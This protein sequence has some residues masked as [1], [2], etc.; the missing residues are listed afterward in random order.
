MI[1]RGVTPSRITIRRSRILGTL[2]L[3]VVIIC[4]AV[5]LAVYTNFGR[6][7][8]RLGLTHRTIVAFTLIANHIARIDPA[9]GVVLAETPDLLGEQFPTMAVSHDGQALFVPQTI[10]RDGVSQDE[11]LVLSA[12]T[13]AVQSSVP[14]QHVVWSMDSWPPALAV[15]S[16]DR[17]VIVSQHGQSDSDPY[18]ISYYDRHTGRVAGDSTVLD[19]CGVSQL[20]PFD[21][22][23][24]VLCLEFGD[25]RFVN[26]PSHRITDTVRLSSIPSAYL[27]APVAAGFIPGER[28]LAVVCNYGGIARVDLDSHVVSLVARLVPAGSGRLDVAADFS[29]NGLAA[30]V[31]AP[32]NSEGPAPA[33]ELVVVDVRTGHLLDQRDIA[34]GDQVAIAPDGARVY[35]VDGQNGLLA[36]DPSTGTARPFG[37]DPSHTRVHLVFSDG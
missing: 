36:L 31:L 24:A 37:L 32:L 35:V 22:Q 14:L 3:V 9:T 25:L 1:A 23:V 11:L 20:L 29:R 5:D 26:V 33:T 12:T 34:S 15:T 19:G 13:L 10:L 6:I 16:D 27:G 2:A 17:T 8:E 21:D 4:L 30:V 7:A 28:A 18:W